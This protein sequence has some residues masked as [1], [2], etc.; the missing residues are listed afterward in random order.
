MLIWHYAIISYNYRKIETIKENT[1]V[2]QI[3]IIRNHLYL[4]YG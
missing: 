1:I 4:N 2:K 3:Q